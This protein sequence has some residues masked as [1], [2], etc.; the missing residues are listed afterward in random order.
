M[1]RPRSVAWAVLIV[2]A[3][4]AVPATAQSPIPPAGTAVVTVA[5]SDGAGFLVI[6]EGYMPGVA[7]R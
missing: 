2:M 1:T 3:L 4:L 7:C 6:A 5:V